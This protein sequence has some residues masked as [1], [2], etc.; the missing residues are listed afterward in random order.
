M[1][2]ENVSED[3]GVDPLSC[4][5]ILLYDFMTSL[6]HC[7]VININSFCRLCPCNHTSTA[8]LPFFISTMPSKRKPTT[9]SSRKRTPKK[10]QKAATSHNVYYPGGGLQTTFAVE[11]ISSLITQYMC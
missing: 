9:P 1:H 10:S 3:E 8:Y 2:V 6:L 4:V 11:G 5:K 7:F